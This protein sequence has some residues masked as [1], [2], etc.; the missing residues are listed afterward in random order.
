MAGGP[1]A[2]GF[3]DQRLADALRTGDVIALTEV[4]DT[5][6]PF[7]YDYCHGLLRDRVEAAGRCAT[8]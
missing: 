8:A 6:A 2:G 5:Y 3:D 1:G 4:Y 7:L